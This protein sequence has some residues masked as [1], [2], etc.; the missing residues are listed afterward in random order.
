MCFTALVVRAAIVVQKGEGGVDAK[1]G[2]SGW[3]DTLI[4]EENKRKKKSKDFLV[5]VW[6]QTSILATM[7]ASPLFS[8]PL[9]SARALFVIYNPPPLSDG[10]QA[11]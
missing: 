3:V 8:L 7:T 4:S 11:C 2:R 6:F 5:C 1:E 10:R 9:Q